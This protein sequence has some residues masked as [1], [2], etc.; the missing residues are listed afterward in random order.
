MTK[1]TS[2]QSKR[3][4]EMCVFALLASVMFCSKLLMEVLPNIHLL[5]MLT[6]T[7]TVVFRRRALVPIYLYVFLNGLYAGFNLWWFPYLYIWTILWGVTMLLPKNW[8]QKTKAI[9]Y[10]IVCALHG[11]LYG[12][13]YAPAQALMFGLDFRGAVAWIMTGIPYDLLHMAGNLLAG[14]LILPL[15]QLLQKLLKGKLS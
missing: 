9:V 4:L 11:L 7:Y 12:I 15:S 5:G 2:T 1:Q 3:T 8:S 6:M 10:P 14:L 13:L